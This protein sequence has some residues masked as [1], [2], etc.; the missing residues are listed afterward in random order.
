MTR[1]RMP[2]SSSLATSCSSARRKS[3]M[4]IETSSAGRRQFSLENANSVRYWIRRSTHARTVARTAST[5]LRWPATRGSRRCFAQRPLPSMMIAICRGM[6]RA[7][8]M[9]R[10]EL[11]NS[12]DKAV[13]ARRLNRHQVRFLGVQDLVDLADEAVSEFLD[14]V[15]GTALV[16]LRNRLR[17]EQVLQVRN[18]IAPDVAHG[19]PR[20]LGF[21]V[22]DLHQLLATLLGERRHWDADHVSGG[23]RIDP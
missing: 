3:C 6:S 2:F 12:M 8:G 22:H 21:L 9:S 11:V 20:V 18:R 7:S 5:P 16:V 1:K 19:D 15:L 23:R 17:L 10:V 4:R 14:V 13:L